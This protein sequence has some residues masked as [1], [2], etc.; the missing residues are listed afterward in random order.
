M[1][2]ECR[3][4]GIAE[5]FITTSDQA[6]LKSPFG[7]ILSQKGFFVF[8]NYRV[9]LKHIKFLLTTGRE[10]MKRI[11]ILFISLVLL[12][13]AGPAYA[14]TLHATDDAYTKEEKPTENNGSDL[15]IIVKDTFPNRDRLGFVKF[16][17]S[18]LPAGID[19][20][21]V[22][23]ATLRL[24]VNLVATGG[25]LDLSLTGVWNEDT[26]T[27]ANAPAIGA[28]IGSIPLT[29][30]DK[31]SFVTLDITDT[32]KAWL[33]GDANNGITAV[34]NDGITIEPSG[35]SAEL[36]SKENEK[37]SHAPEIEVVLIDQDLLD[38]VADLETRVTNL[39]G[40]VT[41]SCTT[42]SPGILVC[43]VIP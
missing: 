5:V 9:K 4:M 33:G 17:L 41:F 2:A 1:K 32:V 29:T 22:E 27:A 12:M 6:I 19:G 35:V 3:F 30:G 43:E 24:S 11:Q 39:E 26:L 25:S 42:T 10:Q 7:T 40:P 8:L 28:F 31:N 15:K 18:T 16:D 13:I 20:T 34:A 37:T 21:N 23:K 36:D 38:Q 14:H